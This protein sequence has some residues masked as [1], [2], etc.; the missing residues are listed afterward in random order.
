MTETTS[1]EQI[2]VTI[3]A[4]EKRVYDYLLQFPGVLDINWKLKDD[5]DNNLTA[6]IFKAIKLSETPECKNKGGW[7]ISINFMF[8]MHKTFYNN[9]NI[10]KHKPLFLGDKKY[11]EYYDPKFPYGR[12]KK[13]YTQ[14][15]NG[16]FNS[17]FGDTQSK[18][19]S[20]VEYFEDE[21][22]F[23]I[24]RNLTKTSYFISMNEDFSR[25]ENT[26]SRVL[27]SRWT[28]SAKDI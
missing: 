3:D 2:S 15:F 25:Y 26:D 6:H 27:V 1:D 28:I 22:I 17:Y 11:H 4:T 9:G 23:I 5:H 8:E 14:F 10:V 12:N 21:L 13:K 18:I 16:L 7:G 20:N 24:E 19:I